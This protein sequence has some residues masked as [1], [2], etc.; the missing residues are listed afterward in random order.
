MPGGPYNTHLIGK[1][2][3]KKDWKQAY[4]YIKITDNIIS[5]RSNKN[6]EITDF[7]E[8]FESM[9][10]KKISFFVSSYNSFLWNTRSSHIIKKHTKSKRHLFENVGQLHLPTSHLFQC[11]HI[12]EAEGYEFVTE[13]LSVQPKINKRNL[14]VATTVYAHNPEKDEL[15]KN[16]KKITLSFFL[17]TGSYATMIVKQIFLRLYEKQ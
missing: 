17:P 9:N 14:I 1:S 16:K 15:H 7:K 4:E 6:G 2:I 3:V 11:P 8:I 12:C 5:N 13:K 10:H